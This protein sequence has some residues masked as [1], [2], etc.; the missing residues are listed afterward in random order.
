MSLKIVVL[1]KQVPD[2]RN[3]G[4]DA[5]TPQGTVNRAALPAIF[6]PEDLNAL[7]QALRLK[8]QNP[9]STIHILTMGPPRATEVI[10]EGL[11]RGTDGGYLLT[12]RAFAGADTLATS[13]ALSMAIRKIGVPDLIIGGRQA[14]DGDTAQVGP[15]VAQ[16][17]GLN[18]I[19]YVTSIDE[20][21]DGQITVTRHIDGGVERVQAPLPLLLTVNGDAA[22]CR[23]RNAKL[24][25]KYKRATAPM[26]RPAEGLPYAEEY[27]KKPYLTVTQWGVADVD[28]DL[29]QC[30]LA[31]SPTKVKTV[32]NIVFKAKESK[33]LTAADA[34]V[35]SLVK[36]LLDS[37]TIG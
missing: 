37:H 18:Q 14:I 13:Y 22:P 10:R 16:K 12:D 11:Y 21:K 1:A 4:P 25:M 5:M 6:N 2:T 23:P 15:Q 36:E 19:T 31:G 32:Q 29:E 26:E 9:G 17:L 34:D 33:Q 28:G 24:V 30:G 27:D 3:V 20:I 8:D 35:E 7:E